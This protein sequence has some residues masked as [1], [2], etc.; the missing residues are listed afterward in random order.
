MSKV[1]GRGELGDVAGKTMIC[2]FH[3]VRKKISMTK[4]KHVYQT[5]LMISEREMH[6]SKTW[7]ELE[8]VT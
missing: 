6:S 3:E 2:S 1:W 5:E 8:V 7:G 4:R